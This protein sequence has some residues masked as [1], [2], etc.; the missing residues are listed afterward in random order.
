MFISLC[1]I[2]VLISVSLQKSNYS[3]PADWNSTWYT[4]SGGH[5]SLHCSL[6]V[7]QVKGSVEATSCLQTLVIY[8]STD[9]AVFSHPFVV[10]EEK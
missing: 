5:A 3:N 7:W 6:Q 4:S 8:P 1:F 10:T 9:E 2:F